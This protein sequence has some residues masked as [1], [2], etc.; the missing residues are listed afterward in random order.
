MRYVVRLMG[1]QFGVYMPGGRGPYGTSLM[2]KGTL[3][4]VLAWRG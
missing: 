2:F 1:D 3:E 4:E